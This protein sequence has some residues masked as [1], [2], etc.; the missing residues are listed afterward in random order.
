MFFI[1]SINLDTLEI[2]LLDF[3]SSKEMAANYLEMA[4]RRFIQREE[5]VRRAAEPFFDSTPDEKI[6]EDGYFLRHNTDKK[7]IDVYK[8]K[9][10]VSTGHI[11]N[12]VNIK[13]KH[14]MYFSIT[15]TAFELAPAIV[16]NKCN[17][18][19]TELKAT[20]AKRYVKYH[21]KN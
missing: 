8:R 3:C 4:A 13:C 2:H 15:E 10:L 9:T 19:M 7:R 16:T 20:L 21:G 6:M 14:I 12:S 18:F 17:D 11:W 5:G 1:Y